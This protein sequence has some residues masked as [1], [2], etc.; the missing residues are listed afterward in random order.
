MARSDRQLTLQAVALHQRISPDR[1]CVTFSDLKYLR[2]EVRRAIATGEIKPPDDGTDNFLDADGHYGPSIYTVTE[3]HLKPVTDLAGKMS[4]ALMRNPEGLNCDVF[5]SHAWQEGIFEFLSKVM[6]SWPHNARHAWCCMLANPQ[7]L[8]ITGLLQSPQHSPFA[9]A[10][11]ASQTVLVVPNRHCSIY[12]RLWCCYEAYLAQE[13]GKVILIAR[14]SNWKEIWQAMT[15][16][17]LAAIVGTLPA[18]LLDFKEWTDHVNLSLICVV[19]ATGVC[20][21]ATARNM[22]RLAL[23]LFGGTMSCFLLVHW[24]GRLGVYSKQAHPARRS[25]DYFLGHCWIAA[26]AM[27]FCFLEL[28]RIHSSNARVEAKQLG[29]GYSGSVVDAVCSCPDDDLRIHREIGGE[30]EA[31]DYAIEVLLSAGMSTP[32]LREVAQKGVSISQAANPQI[33]LTVLLLG[34]GTTFTLIVLLLEM[35]KAGKEAEQASFWLTMPSEVLTLAVRTLIILYIWLQPRDERCFILYVVQ[36]T[37]GVYLLLV[38]AHLAFTRSTTDL[39]FLV[40]LLLSAIMLTFT[41][42]GLR[43]TA[44]LPF[45]CFV[46]Q[47]FFARGFYAHLMAVRLCSLGQHRCPSSSFLKPACSSESDSEADAE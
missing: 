20:S 45:G 13:Q 26:L 36:K 39:F 10:L 31:V 12:T 19:V 24:Q 3:Q 22:L 23:N 18:W 44:R 32:T 25:I 35:M 2:R 40:P 46:V 37:T 27:T 6:H 33:A 8:D 14:A 5:I 17:S 42:L 28:D 38:A 7:H 4:W 11:Q 15:Y 21:M 9:I 30:V 29:R 43:R 41:M 16:M 34:V 47:I 1:W